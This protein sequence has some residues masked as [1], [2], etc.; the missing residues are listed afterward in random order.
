MMDF[1]KEPI[2][3]KNYE[4]VLCKCNQAAKAKG[5]AYFTLIFQD[6][7]GGK[8][9]PDF[10]KYELSSCGTPDLKKCSYEE[11]ICVGNNG[12][13]AVYFANCRNSLGR[14]DAAKVTNWGSWSN[15]SN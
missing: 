11:P 9:I 8:E 10:S 4:R 1:F 2:G 3:P 13:I 14:C 15:C 12:E 7:W 6:C 5:F